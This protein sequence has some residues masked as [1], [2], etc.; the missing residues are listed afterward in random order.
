MSETWQTLQVARDARLSGLDAVYAKLIDEATP[1]YAY[2]RRTK[3]NTILKFW[4]DDGDPDDD[5]YEPDPPDVQRAAWRR[6]VLECQSRMLEWLEP[7]KTVN[8]D[9]VLKEIYSDHGISQLAMQGNPLFAMLQPDADIERKI[10]EVT[11]AVKPIFVT[12]MKWPEV[13]DP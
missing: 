1:D 12:A 2:V 7:L 13:G 8:F 5:Q 11:D 6:N 4:L 10:Q 3:R 9:A